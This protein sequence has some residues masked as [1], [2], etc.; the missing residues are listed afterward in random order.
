MERAPAESSGILT[1]RHWPGRAGAWL[2]P[3]SLEP[4]ENDAVVSLLDE[5]PAGD[6]PA[7]FPVAPGGW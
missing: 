7:T 6:P 2:L 1:R 5:H 3:G 4:E